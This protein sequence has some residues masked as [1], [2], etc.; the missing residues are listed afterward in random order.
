MKKKL[1]KVLVKP[2]SMYRLETVSLNKKQKVKLEA[3]EIKMVR[4]SLGVTKLDKIKNKV[5]RKTVQAGQLHDKLR[6]SR[7]RLFMNRE[8]KKTK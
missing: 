4:Y 8:D 2:A 7:V 1:Y 5:I 6:E 3:A